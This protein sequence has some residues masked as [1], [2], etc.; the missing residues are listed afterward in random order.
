LIAAV[1]EELYVEEGVTELLGDVAAI[2]VRRFPQVIALALALR[3]SWRKDDFAQMIARLDAFGRAAP[4][5]I[6]NSSRM[7]SVKRA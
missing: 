1:L 3:H 6:P 5:S 7:P 4:R 2:P